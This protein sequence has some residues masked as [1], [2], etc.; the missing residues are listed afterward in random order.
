[1]DLTWA[2]CENFEGE[3]K[4]RSQ[5]WRREGGRGNDKDEDDEEEADEEK[6][7]PETATKI[8]E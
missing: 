6:E 5:V 2:F 7:E 8:N 4:E 3:P 1:L